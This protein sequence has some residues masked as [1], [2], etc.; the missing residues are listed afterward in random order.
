[1]ELFVGNGK[2]SEIVE[3]KE[4]MYVRFNGFIS[5]IESINISTKGNAYVHLK[6]P[7]GLL[8]HCNKE[9]INKAS[10]NIIDLIEVGDYVNG[11]RIQFITNKKKLLSDGGYNILEK[12]TNIQSILTKEQFEREAYKI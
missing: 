5:K 12:Y 4:G 9:L 7:N 11:E 6:E 2:G 10:Y 8:A 3:L 1:M